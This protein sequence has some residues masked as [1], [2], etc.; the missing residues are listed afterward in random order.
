MKKT[1][2]FIIT[3]LSTSMYAQN[4]VVTADD[5]VIVGDNTTTTIDGAIKYDGTDFYGLKNGS[6]QS[7]TVQSLWQTNGTDL[8]TLDNVGIGIANPQKTLHV[9]GSSAGNGIL[10]TRAGT[11]VDTEIWS[12]FNEGGIGTTSNHDFRF[13]TN[14]TFR[15]EIS[16]N[17]NWGIGTGNTNPIEVLDVDG[18]INIGTTSNNNNGS[19]KYTGSD[20]EGRVGSEWMSLTSSN[21]NTWMSNSNLNNAAYNLDYN[22]GW[23]AIGPTFT[24]TKERASTVLELSYNS[25]VSIGSIV[26]GFGVQFQIRVNANEGDQQS[27]GSVILGNLTD[28]IMCTSIF[29]SLAAGSHTVQIYARAANFGSTANTVI[30]DPGGWGARII[31]REY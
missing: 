21:A 7:L 19:I 1:L 31:A 20:F 9:E 25:R 5:G 6:W 2:L 10:V 4:G 18:A 15:G 26:S 12:N 30:L 11:T 14:G 17:G 27:L 22:N 24:F 29:E 28:N 8:Y 16:A 23:E 3:I 13:V